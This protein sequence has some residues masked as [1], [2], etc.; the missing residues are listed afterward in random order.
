MARANR[1]AEGPNRRTKRTASTATTSGGGGG[2]SGSGSGAQLSR[3]TTA[4][5]DS[6]LDAAQRD[7]S[8][9]SLLNGAP[10][11]AVDRGLQSPSFASSMEQVNLHIFFLLDCSHRVARFQSLNA[12]LQRPPPPQQQPQMGALLNRPPAYNFHPQLAP[13]SATTSTSYN[14][15]IAGES[16]LFGGAPADIVVPASS[17]SVDITPAGAS[18]RVA[19]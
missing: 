3:Q 7:E 11:A 15:P 17:R 10:L 1:A 2:G 14:A 9:D 13:S 4:A 19:S 8:C 5:D 12:P 18:N 6:T 16:L